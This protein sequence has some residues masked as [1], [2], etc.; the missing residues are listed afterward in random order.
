MHFK[1]PVLGASKK[2]SV[3]FTVS[4]RPE[5][6][7]PF[8]QR[9]DIMPCWSIAVGAPLNLRSTSKGYLL[10]GLSPANLN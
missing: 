6:H 3:Q 7:V 1:R 10:Y 8:H 4:A 2:L 5:A 9:L